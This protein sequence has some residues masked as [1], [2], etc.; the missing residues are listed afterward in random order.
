MVELYN[1]LSMVIKFPLIKHESMGNGIVISNDGHH[2]IEVG[3]AD[4]GVKNLSLDNPFITASNL[5][6]LDFIN[7]ELYEYIFDPATKK[8]AIPYISAFH[9]KDLQ[10]T[11]NRI[12]GVVLGSGTYHF[13]IEINMSAITFDCSC[14]VMHLCKHLYA[15]CV[16]LK[17]NYAKVN[18]SSFINKE[19][20][21]RK[22]RP[23]LD[24]YL[25]Y[26][27]DTTNFRL[28]FNIYDFA[29]KDENLEDFL[30]ECFSY[31]NRNQYH[32]KIIDALLFP[33][34][35]DPKL[36]DKFQ[37]YLNSGANE[38]VKR[39]LNEVY[40]Y[41]KT[42]N[43]EKAQKIKSH[44][45]KYDLLHMVFEQDPSYFL[46]L[47][48]VTE[49]DY[50]S[51]AYCLSQLASQK[52]LTFDEI[53]AINESP[54]F[55]KAARTIYGIF[56]TYRNIVGNNGLLF[57]EQSSHPEQLLKAAP[58]DFIISKISTSNN[59]IRFLITANERFNEIKM[60]DYEKVIEAI[61][62]TV[63]TNDVSNTLQREAIKDLVNRFPN[64]KYLKEIVD[65]NVGYK[66]YWRY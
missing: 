41:D 43:Y 59:P 36:N 21:A 33:L 63:L 40:E 53:T 51:L 57:I 44:R 34:T 6:V 48:G 54:D 13:S 50:Q 4:D 17:K 56:I 27:I 16:F 10:I 23:L 37:N 30:V 39:M 61:I 12:S 29:T 66:P 65:Y 15:A 46:N 19:N 28:L 26:S 14:P 25:Y 20:K 58:I 31:Y 49:K 32:N 64:N 24:N 5:T 42:F 8:K 2:I 22:I 38:N 3:F 1:K 55:Q 9:I 60:D 11:P 45:I 47:E 62:Y 35:F 18:E 7:E 52:E